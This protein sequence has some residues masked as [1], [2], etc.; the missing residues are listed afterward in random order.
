MPSTR[1]QLAKLKAKKVI[2]IPPK[3]DT[4]LFQKRGDSIEAMPIPMFR[5][6]QE[7]LNE[8]DYL[9]LM[10]SNLSTFQ[11]IKFETVHYTLVGPE[12]WSDFDFCADENKEATVLH[13]INSVKDKS[14]QIAMRFKSATQPL[15]L[16]YRHLFEGIGKL[17]VELPRFKCDFPFTVFNN[18]RHLKLSHIG[19]GFTQASFDWDCLEKLELNHC[20]IVK[21]LA[22]NSSKSLKSLT[23]LGCSSLTTIPPL[24]NIEDVYICATS[25]LTH[26]QSS[27]N[28]KKFTCMGSALERETLELITNPSF[29]K[30]LHNVTLWCTFNIPEFTFCQNIPVVDLFHTSFAYRNDVYPSLPILNGREIKLK[31][32]SL[33]FWN[34]QVLS[35]MVKCELRNCIGLIDFPE[36]PALRVLWLMHCRDL[37]NIPSL[38]SLKEL[39]IRDCPQLRRIGLL[40]SFTQVNIGRCPALDHSEIRLGGIKKL[41]Q[42]SLND[43]IR[44]DLLLIL[45]FKVV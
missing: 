36:M 10:N 20:C 11:P 6:I 8:Q 29:C 25:R 42:S 7:F 9:D 16:E 37:K 24:D 39:I 4:S 27:G 35:N 34:E 23:F 43:Y 38:P 5:I 1:R 41:T 17:T 15:L 14:K 40:P 28:H 44:L 26:F 31:H 33:V 22:W 3:Y 19:E 32:F 18:I 12:R 13:I 21:I 2:A 45:S 30:S